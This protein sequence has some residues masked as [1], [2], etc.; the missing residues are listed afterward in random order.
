EMTCSPRAAKRVYASLLASCDVGLSLML[1]PHP[2]LVPLEMAAAGLL[3][4]TN[5]YANK[6]AAALTALSTNL[7]AAPPTAEGVAAGLAEAIAAA[8]DVDRRVA[9]SRVA[10]STS[11]A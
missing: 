6:N 7:I 11:W 9:G 2:S 5:T 3:T 10:W 1:T 4:V 8:D